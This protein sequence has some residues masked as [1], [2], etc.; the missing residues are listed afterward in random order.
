M[1]K[2][3]INQTMTKIIKVWKHGNKWGCNIQIGAWIF[4]KEFGA[5]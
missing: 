5:N 3:S 1:L 4:W 2:T